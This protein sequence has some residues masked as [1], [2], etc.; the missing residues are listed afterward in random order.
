M[1]KQIQIRNFKAF[2]SLSTIDIRPLTVLIGRNSCGKSSICKLVDA[3]GEAM[4][5]DASGYL[6][7]QTER[8][9]LGD[10]YEDLFYQRISNDLSLLLKF[11]GDISLECS[12]LMQDGEFC[13]R[14]YK[15]VK[16]SEE[17]HLTFSSKEESRDAG[18]LG[19]Y[20]PSVCDKSNVKHED[21]FFSVDYIGPIRCSAK[22]RIER[23]GMKKNSYVGYKGHHAYDMLLQSYLSNGELLQSVSGWCASYMDNQ[24][25]V[26]AE[27]AP[28]TGIFSLYVERNGMRVNI[29]DVGEGLAQL[30]PII[31][32]SFVRSSDITIVEQPSL[33]LNSAAHANVACRLAESAIALGKKYIIETHSDTFLTGLKKMVVKHRL[34]K[35][36]FVI[37]Y[38]NHDGIEASLERIELDHNYEYT[39]WPEGMFEDDYRLQ[40]EISDLLG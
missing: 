32:Q 14:S 25:L 1:L 16:G 6:P 30:L 19:L 21:V 24:R 20:L 38:V 17:N 22:R 35:E 10:T 28:G 12:F 31:T 4:T 27:Q 33:H 23:V 39:S 8:N 18:F 7:I 40:T 2:H 9:R 5:D 29:A 15:V 3:L 37:Y 13:P 34:P 36:D 26:M 11:D